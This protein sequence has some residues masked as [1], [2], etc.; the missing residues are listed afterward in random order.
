MATESKNDKSWN[1]IFKDFDVLKKIS[2]TGHFIIT[3]EQ[4][5]KYRESR[6]MTKFDHEIN[7]PEIFKADKLSI[8]PLSRGSY[9]IARFEAY[10]KV[11]Y[12]AQ[13]PE[14]V[15][16]RTDLESLDYN[17]IYS[18]AAAINCAFLSG[19]IKDV[20][21]EEGELTINGRMS[22]R[23]FD[24]V[25]NTNDTG[26]SMAVKVENSQC[27]IDAGFESETKLVLLEAKNFKCDDFLIRQIYYPYRLWTGKINKKVIPIFMTYSN[28]MFSFFIYEFTD[29]KNYNSLKLVEQK[30]YEIASEPINMEDIKKI[31]GESKLVVEPKVPFPQADKFDRVVDLIGLLMNEDLTKDK[32]TSEYDFDERQTNYYT[33]A[34]RYLGLVEKHKDEIKVIRFKITDECKKILLQPQKTKNLEL[35][36]LIILHKPFYEVLKYYLEK[37]GPP[38]V[39]YVVEVMKKS[40]LYKVDSKSTYE[41]RAQSVIKWVEWIINLIDE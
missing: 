30:N 8:M 25:I 4:I 27:E 14:S 18:E 19:I 7:L 21:G 5:N 33:D 41:R 40:K 2:K 11:D 22:S 29:E 12:S 20:I 39:D 28:G 23:T 26:K 15:P 17:N 24:F 16:K 10:Q 38:S 9:I 13:K 36:R 37:S 6:L 3:S 32:I 1:E 31:L 34:A 35:A